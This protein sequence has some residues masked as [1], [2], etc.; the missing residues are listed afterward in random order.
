MRHSLEC[1]VPLLDLQLVRFIESLPTRYR[2]RLGEGKV[3]HKRVAERALP[4]SI[5]RRKKKGFMAPT[6]RWFRENNV[7]RE[8]LLDQ[9]SRFS[10]YL[11]RRAVAEVLDQHSRGFNRERHI[12]LLLGLHYWMQE[13]AT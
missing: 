5:V 10:S 1:R 8:L 7:V 3:I 2:V 11:D 13:F 6:Q 4:S 12:F 9:S